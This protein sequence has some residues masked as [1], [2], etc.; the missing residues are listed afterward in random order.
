MPV[1][2]LS[3]IAAPAPARRRRAGHWPPR[4]S[5][6]APLAGVALVAFAV[7]AIAGQRHE[8]PARAIARQWADAWSRGD[9]GAMHK[10]LTRPARRRASLARLERTYRATSETLTLRRV[11]AGRP[12]QERDGAYALPVRFD[13]RIFGRLSGSLRLPIVEVDG[14]A[15]VDWRSNLVYPGLRGGEKLTRE[16]TLPARGPI[17]ARDGTALA[18]GPDRLSDLGPLAAEVAGRVG[19]PPPER[20]G[21]LAQRGVPRRARVGLNGLEREFDVRLSGRPGGILRAGGR[22]IARADAV[23]GEEVRSSIDPAVQRAAVE[24]LAGRFGGVAVLKPTTGEVLALAGIAYSAPQPPGSTF[25]IVTLAGA[26]EA[27][28]VSKRD[29]FPVETSTMLEGVKLENANGEAC[30]GTLRTAFAESC[31]SV[32]A[33]LGAKLG[34]RRLVDTARR[35]GFNEQPTLAG[36]ARSSLPSAEEIGDDLAVG[37]TAIGQ[38]KVLATPLQLA[39]VAAT[40]GLHGRRVRPTLSRGGRGGATQ[41][42][43]RRVARVIARYMRAV[44]TSGTGAGASIPGARV[45]GKTGTAELRNTVIEDPLPLE[46]G[47]EPTPVP[48]EDKTDTDAWFAAFA[49][50]GK[51]RVALAV[52][53]VG[54]GAGG[55]TAAPAARSVLLAA[56]KR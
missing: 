42:V 29:T 27:G 44:V 31:N 35:F 17:L 23:P 20:A 3:P 22:S 24:A 10:L 25:K 37:S 34:A 40:I 8:P 54:Q 7:G 45:A 38:G 43:P 33:P 14:A 36:A 11:E 16:T 5:R 2:R 28:V 21:E 46:P 51:P 56:L 39:S 41:A 48:E 1:A 47:A 15:G 18:R 53:L 50:Y 9:Y 6:L 26:L 4:G 30:G 52:L 55:E 12:R 13:T 49:P 19:Q 32:F